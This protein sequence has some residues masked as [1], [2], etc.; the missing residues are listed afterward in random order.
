M[1]I[2]RLPDYIINRLKAGEIVNR[3]VSVIKE[4]VENSIDAGADNIIISVDDGGKSLISVED[5]GSGIQLSDMDLV[6]ER[7]ATSKINNENDLL[8]IKNYGFRGEALASIAEVSK[9]TVISKTKY[10]EIATKLIRRGG[11]NIIKNVP[12]GFDSGTIVSVEDIF[13]NVPVRLKFMKSPQ[14]EFYYCYNYFV[15]ISLWHYNK[16]FVLKK[17]GKVVFDLEPSDGIIDRI[18]K[19]YKKDRSKN[20]KDVSYKDD[21]VE[22]NAVVGDSSLR[23]GS[24]ENIKIYVNSRPIEDKVIKKSLMDAYYRQITPGEYPLAVL[25]FEIDPEYVDVNVHPSKLQ[26]KF[27][28]S[29]KIYEIVYSQIKKVLGENRIS[30]LSDLGEKKSDFSQNLY[31]KETL[32]N[33]IEQKNLISNDSSNFYVQGSGFFEQEEEKIF[34]NEFIGEYKIVG[35]LRNSYVM[36]ESKDSLFYIDQHALAERIAFEKMKK[37]RDLKPELLLQPLKFEVINI[38]NLQE[39]IDEINK[40]GFDCSLISENTLVIYA[41]PK[42]FV[43]YPVDLIKLLNHILYLKEISYDHMLDGLFATRAC[44]TSIKAGHRL[45]MQQMLNLIKEGFENI[46][47]LFVCQHGRPFF[48]QVEKK[49]IDKLF[50]R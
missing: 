9:I 49:N 1:A 15:D 17:N 10:S 40:F 36:L 41:V 11:E 32:D 37:E 25:M 28:D 19:L 29:R 16:H 46:E 23:F 50:D 2:N 26:V 39:K 12:V 44:K 30:N 33:S 35:Q 43:L 42:V 18:N 13:Y 24:A 31:T 8:H 14:T 6:L 5:N 27:R 4:L 7:Y 34:E 47:G 3:P 20:L 48:V 22:F 21:I 45:S 38:P